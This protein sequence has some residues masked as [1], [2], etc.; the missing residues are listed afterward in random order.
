MLLISYIVF[1]GM[2]ATTMNINMYMRGFSTDKIDFT[3]MFILAISYIFCFFVFGWKY[4]LSA[5]VIFLLFSRCAL[6]LCRYIASRILGFKVGYQETSGLRGKSAASGY[7]EFLERKMYKKL[8]RPNMQIILNENGLTIDDIVGQMA[9]LMLNGFDHG[10]ACEMFGSPKQ[11]QIYFEWKNKC[12]LSQTIKLRA[13]LLY[14]V[15]KL[16]AKK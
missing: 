5:I 8:L 14:G 4:T 7:P 11:I 13:M 12:N 1:M 2:L 3:L 15:D 6:P 10:L 9:N 16:Q